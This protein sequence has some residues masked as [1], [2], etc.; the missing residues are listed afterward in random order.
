LNPNPSNDIAT[1]GT[2]TRFT[3]ENAG[4]QPS[5]RRAAFQEALEIQQLLLNDIRN[6][7]IERSDRAAL[8][9]AWVLVEDCKRVLR[10]IPTPGQLRPDLDPVQLA[11]A[12]KR[13]RS[14]TSIDIPQELAAIL[15]ADASES[16]PHS[17][18]QPGPNHNEEA[19]RSE[20]AQRERDKISNEKGTP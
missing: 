10:G 20:H 3:A 5:Y 18:T 16:P 17:T 6:Q 12:N 11:R 9:R 2:A 14:R 8:V 7:A 1:L 15:P 19:E 13:A 4:Q